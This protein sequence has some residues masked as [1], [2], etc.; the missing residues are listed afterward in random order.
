MRALLSASYLFV[1]GL[2]SAFAL[3]VMP[4]AE[5][6]WA[7]VGDLGQ[8]SPANLG[9]NATFGVVLTADGVVLIDSG[10]SKKGAEAIEQVIRTVTDKPVIA[11]INTGGQD[12]RWL[13]NSFWTGKG[14]RI[15][16]S[17]AAVADQREQFDMQWAVL[18]ALVG[19]D[20]LSGTAPAYAKETFQDRVDI[21]IGGTRFVL[22]HVG[23]AHTAGDTYVWLPSSRIVFAGD[24]MFTD[25]MLGI[26]PVSRIID[27]IAAF[28]AV[29]DLDP[30]IVVPGHGRPAPLSRAVAETRAYLTYLRDAVREVV[31]VGGTMADAARIDQSQFRF[32]AGSNELAGRNAQAVF[33]QLEFEN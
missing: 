24:T 20:G 17:A 11:V 5:N 28:D 21:V 13:G 18:L 15:I 8:R 9:N 22:R 32:L 3:E 30:A 10:G 2:Q 23:P 26:L 6:V 12:H 33:E 1:V 7:V 16:A 14:A 31:K 25:R 29:S 19:E 4:V 27:W